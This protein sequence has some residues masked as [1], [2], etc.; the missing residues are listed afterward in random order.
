MWAAEN[1]G[2]YDRSKLLYP[3]D[4]GYQGPEFQKALSDILP[5]LEIEIVKR[6]AQAKG[7]VLRPRRWSSNEPLLGCASSQGWH[8]Q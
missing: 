2:R 3:S 6:P 1:R 5:V 8:V 7:F 4:S